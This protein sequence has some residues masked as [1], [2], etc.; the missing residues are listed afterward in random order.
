MSI[1]VLFSIRAV[2]ILI[3]LSSSL[4]LI[5]ITSSSVQVRYHSNQPHLVA[6]VSRLLPKKTNKKIII[7]APTLNTILKTTKAAGKMSQ[8]RASDTTLKEPI[9][10]LS[11]KGR[12][13][14]KSS[15]TSSLG[16]NTAVGLRPVTES[17]FS[18]MQCNDKM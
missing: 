15:T 14:R 2:S 6:I 5:S 9:E 16:G 17:M 11:Y 13:F 4:F 18:S 7:I 12:K 10:I 1:S 8:R 3:H